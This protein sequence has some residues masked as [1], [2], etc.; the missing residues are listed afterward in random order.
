MRSPQTTPQAEILTGNPRRDAGTI[1]VA[2]AADGYWSATTA[3]MKVRVRKADGIIILNDANGRHVVTQLEPTQF[4]QGR[5]TVTLSCKPSEYFFGGGVQNG[6]F[7]HRGQVIAIENTNNWVDGGVAS[8]SPFYWSTAGY[9]VMAYT[10]SP[11]KYDFGAS[12]ASQ[13]RLTHNSSYLDL[14]LMVNEGCVPLLRDYYQLT[15]NPVLLPKFG[16]YE[17]HLNAY[18]RDYWKDVTPVEDTDTPDAQTASADQMHKAMTS[19]D[20]GQQGAIVFED[21]RYYK[22]S[23]TDNGGIR[24]SL[25]GELEGN[26]QF[27]ARA[28]IDRY[29]AA[30]MPLGW[31]LPNDGYGAGYGQTTTLDGN[32][33]NLRSFGEY[34]RSK[35]VEIGLWTQSDL[36]PKE[37]V[38]ALLQRDIIKEVRDA[39]VRVLKTD[40]AW[41]GAGY[42]FGLNGVADVGEVMP[43][44]GNNAR[45]FII[46]LDG[47]AG[48]QRYAGIW[49]GDQTG[50]E[51]EYIR[52]HIPT[53][54][55]SGLSGQ[56]NISSDMDGIFGGKNTA[57]NVRDF[58]WKTFTPMQLNMDGWG[59]NA[60][61]PQALGEP[62]TSINR[63]YLKLKSI[64]MPYLYSVAHEAT[65]GLPMIRAMFLEEANPFT[66]GTSTRYQFMCGPSILVAPIYQ[67]TDADEQ[68]ND[69][70]NDIYLPEGQWIDFFSGECYEGGQILNG[71]NTPLWKLPVFIRRGSIIPLT[72][73]HN[74]PNQID[75]KLRTFMFYPKE[76]T[77]ITVYD[78]DG[79]TEEYRSGA[80]ASTKVES[81]LNEKKK[82][83]T[84][85]VH[86]T[87]GDF[88]GFEK[89]QSTEFIVNLQKKP[90]KIVARVDGYKVDLDKAHNRKDFTEN[91]D[92]WFYDPAP[93]Y[94]RFATGGTPMAEISVQHSP[95]LYVRIAD[96]DI[97]QS[98]LTL[99]IDGY[100]YDTSNKKLH[101]HGKISV[102]VLRQGDEQQAYSITP[103]WQGVT[104]ADYYELKLTSGGENGTELVSTPIYTQ[105]GADESDTQALR[106]TTFTFN[107]LKPETSY[108]VAIRAVNADGATPW[109]TTV[110]RTVADPLRL[111][112]H[113]VTAETSCPNQ[114]G[115]DISHLFDFDEKTIWHTAWSQPAVPF[116]MMIDLHAI[117]E[118]DKLQYIPR[119]DAGNG[120]ITRGS[121]QTSIDRINWSDKQEFQWAADASTKTLTLSTPSAIRYIRL[122]VDDAHGSFGSGQQLYVFRKEG[123]EAMLPGDINHDNRVDENDLKSY[124]NYTGL[125]NGDG[126]FEGYISRGDLNRNGLIDAYDISAVA[127]ELE[128]GVSSRRVEPVAGTIRVTTDRKTAQTGDII[129]LTVSGKGLVS[130]NAIS[131]AIP[132]DASR[133]EYVGIQPNGTKEARNLTCDRLHTNGQKALYPTFVNC[134][135]KP[136]F[137]DG[138]LMVIR[139]RAKKNGTVDLQPQDGMLIDKYLNVK[140]F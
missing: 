47:W 81:E 3:Q 97:T 52:F 63:T 102:P 103:S 46:S 66:L 54:I 67:N 138:T 135:E 139:F 30:D 25:N 87:E 132:Y 128:T 100:T 78:D 50:G 122:H 126:D 37:G 113:N 14:F 124:M 51:W 65:D 85:T 105:V 114:P 92:V 13:V 94:N 17:G 24:E 11:G 56:P 134:G 55:G 136:Y 16:F 42:S 131:M 88:K 21:G 83:L 58:Q 38:E 140:G 80:S 20:D 74:N 101:K 34:A 6:R 18:N 71:F 15:G 23:Q 104:G 77:E 31:V 27:S 84:I 59:T 19:P 1:S 86:P 28:V 57:V 2:D 120:T 9:A 33:A 133:F 73:S 115:Q 43:R 95:R 70:R 44:Y 79:L 129:R 39:G 123:T 107:D 121:I 137:E 112:L 35:G 7:S 40:V 53:Y 22:E 110:F 12:N 8:P 68:G 45:P 61:Y 32:I 98:T 111:A 108:E 127:I 41:V 60:K 106:P 76:H 36:H 48:T 29:E 117:A 109:A 91:T 130:A 93:E 69:I 125:R 49:S 89:N 72:H 62:A 119:S 118:V 4:E 10:F 75:R 96:K 64:L 116:D 5:T 99:E 26:Y 90:K 82:Y